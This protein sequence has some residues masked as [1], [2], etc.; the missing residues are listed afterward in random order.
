MID[1]LHEVGLVVRL[2]ITMLKGYVDSPQTVVELARR[3]VLYHLAEIPESNAS[4]R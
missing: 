2:S 4:S 1:R 3:C